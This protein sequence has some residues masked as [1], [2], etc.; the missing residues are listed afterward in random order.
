[1]S[2]C[3]RRIQESSAGC[4]GGQ[5]HSEQNTRDRRYKPYVAALAQQRTA[6]PSLESLRGSYSHLT[7]YKGA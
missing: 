1:M 4:G 7:L 2:P 5:T 6:R 3:F